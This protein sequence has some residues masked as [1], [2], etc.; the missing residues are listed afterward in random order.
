MRIEFPHTRR[1]EMVLLLLS[2]VIVGLFVCVCVFSSK[3][4]TRAAF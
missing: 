1:E 4:V 2:D 3:S